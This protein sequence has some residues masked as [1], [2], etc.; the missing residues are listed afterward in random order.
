MLEKL[1]A[2]ESFA[3]LV[4][5]YSQDQDTVETGGELGWLAQD[6]MGV[7]PTLVDAALALEPGEIS[8]VIETYLGF[9]ILTVDERQSDYPLDE[10][11]LESRQSRAVVEWLSQ[12]RETATIE[13][14]LTP[15]DVPEEQG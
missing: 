3:D 8:E 11:T 13:E 7:V 14:T 4:T 12:A 2:G 6:Q 5:E 1:N 15:E 9:H 10:A